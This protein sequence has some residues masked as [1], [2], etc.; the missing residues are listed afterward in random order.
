V[1]GKSK[2]TAKNAVVS[3]E[4]SIWLLMRKRM[5]LSV[6]T[7]RK[8]R[9][10]TADG[11]YDTR[12]GHDELRRRKISSLIH[13]RKEALTGRASMPTVTVLLRISG[14]AEAMPGGQKWNQ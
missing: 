9:S 4:N 1:S 11:A 14:L 12:L 3:G 8:I 5:K 13:P 7:C 6:L 2:N 10:T